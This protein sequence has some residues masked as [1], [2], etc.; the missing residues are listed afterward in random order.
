[1]AVV[2][3]TISATGDVDFTDPS[4]T[5]TFSAAVLMWSGFETDST[6]HTH[7]VMG[8][9]FIAVEPGALQEETA[10]CIQAENGLSVNTDTGTRHGAQGQGI[11][12]VS[13]T[14]AVSETVLAT[15]KESISGGFR[16]TVGTFSNPTPI[17]V[18]AVIFAG[19]ARAYADLCASSPLGTHEDVG[20]TTDFEPDCVFFIAGDA[21]VGNANT[22]DASPN[23]GFAVNDGG[24]SQVCVYINADD[25]VSTSDAD[26]FIRTDAAYA[27]APSRTAGALNEARVTVDA[28]DSTGFDHTSTAGSPD[29]HYLALKFSGSVNIACANMSVA[30]ATGD[31]TFNAFGFTPQVVIGMSTLLGSLD[32]E[33]DGATA[34]ASGYFITGSEGSR[35]ITW[36]HR[37]GNLLSSIPSAASTRQEDVAVLTYDHL[38]NVAQRATWVGG[39]GTGFTLNFSVATAGYL[40]AI[41]IGAGAQTLVQNETVG[42]T[43][44]LTMFGSRTVVFNETVGITETCVSITNLVLTNRVP[45]GWTLSG[46]SERGAVLRAGAEAGTVL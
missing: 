25:N 17:K 3:V 39:T 23:I 35:A 26:G 37:E 44:A 6:D 22:V 27:H 13:G 42:I 29:A 5:E 43:E 16:M 12:V 21:T 46:G 14:N 45:A 31:Q 38:G 20:G 28:F 19:L 41:G 8:M 36:R 34:S 32:T 4:I 15:Y 10:Y 9:G 7:G 40:T 11:V 18:T 2:T 33:I 1:M 30:A 24:P